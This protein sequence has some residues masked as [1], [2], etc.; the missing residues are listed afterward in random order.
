MDR[1]RLDKIIDVVNGLFA[2]SGFECIEAEWQTREKALTLYID[3]PG[4]V[5]IAAC[6]EANRLLRDAAEIDEMVPGQYN[7]EV[8]SPGVERPLRRRAHFES[9]IGKVITVKLTEKVQDRRVA[10]GKIL[11]VEGEGDESRVTMTTEQGGSWAFP[12]RVLQRAN[13]VFE[14]GKR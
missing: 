1:V 10:T 6:E 13:L 7:L 3:R 9:H 5:D 11:S 14:W 4:G 12:I 2:G 8:S